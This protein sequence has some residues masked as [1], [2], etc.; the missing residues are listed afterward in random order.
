MFRIH[1]QKKNKLICSFLIASLLWSL[2]R[3]ATLHN[4]EGLRTGNTDAGLRDLPQQQTKA[5][6]SEQTT[7]TPS[8]RVVDFISFKEMKAPGHLTDHYSGM[9]WARRDI[10][11]Q[12]WENPYWMMAVMASFKVFDMF[13]EENVWMTKD[14]LDF[15]V[16]HLSHYF[17]YMNVHEATAY[18]NFRVHVQ[19]QKDYMAKVNK[20]GPYPNA[21]E[22]AF[23]YTIGIMPYYRAKND[24]FT[25]R[26]LVDLQDVPVGK[27]RKQY[28]YMLSI[29]STL[30]SLWQL[31]LRRVIV[32][33]NTLEEPP[34][35]REAFEIFQKSI[36]TSSSASSS[37]GMELVYVPTFTED[38]E[39]LHTPTYALE[40]LRMAFNGSMPESDKI[41]WLGSD[42]D[43]WKYIYFSE[44]DL[45]LHTRPQSIDALSQ[46]I[47]DGKILAAHR[48]Q[49]LPH[50]VDFPHDDDSVR[51]KD[52]LPNYGNF[53]NSNF[54]NVDAHDACCDVQE[55]PGVGEECQPPY[56]KFP[57]W[58]C[59][60]LSS[61]KDMTPAE[62]YKQHHRLFS[63]PMIRLVHGMNVTAIQEH[64][65]LCLPV[66]GG[67]CSHG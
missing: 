52:Y 58:R 59:G 67:N 5:S 32:A 60:F 56:T 55:W 44:P 13:G 39:N 30:A 63:H 37:N 23:N 46:A 29:S 17:K 66:K 21:K 47:Q 31:G 38:R 57:W 22:S 8:R 9:W 51:I 36:S 14:W 48:F 40:Q 6:V 49:L 65:R 20:Q 15:C 2:F 33:G 7:A 45:I 1:H 11:V 28:L 25:S 4:D 41:R 35:V 43:Q 50:Q 53:S 12:K 27:P 3:T 64:G 18:E 16:E 61:S 62:R 10:F 42:L 34:E 19:K 26:S 54:I 24:S